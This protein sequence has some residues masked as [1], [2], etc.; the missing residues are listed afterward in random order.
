M[1]MFATDPPCLYLNLAADDRACRAS[2]G[3]AVSANKE[4]DRDSAPSLGM[5]KKK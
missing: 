2:T 5:P 3:L 1:L 4:V